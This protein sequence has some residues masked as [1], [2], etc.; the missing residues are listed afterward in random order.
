M[1]KQLMAATALVAAGM[2]AVSGAALAQKKASKPVLKL[3][4]YFEAILGAINDD[5]DKGDLRHVGVDVQQDAEIFFKGSV[6]LDNGRIVVS[7]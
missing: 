7:N 5:L 6:T 2:L 1:K 4:G 3:G